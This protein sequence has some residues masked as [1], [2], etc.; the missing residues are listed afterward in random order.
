[1]LLKPNIEIHSFSTTNEKRPGST[2]GRIT[3]GQL[4]RQTIAVPES[5]SDGRTPTSGKRPRP[6]R[7]TIASAVASRALTP[8]RDREVS[9]APS[10][11]SA[12]IQNDQAGI[13]K[14]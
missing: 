6:T 13:F 14:K 10:T 9:Q 12:I 8:K 5:P 4:A 1:M 11:S 7:R 3:R 2:T